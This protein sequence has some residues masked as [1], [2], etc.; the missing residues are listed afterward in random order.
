M[1]ATHILWRDDMEK[2]RCES[3]GLEIDTE[4]AVDIELEYDDGVQVVKTCQACAKS[5]ILG[6]RKMANHQRDP[7]EEHNWDRYGG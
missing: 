2:T 1:E 5:F 6:V 4:K 3:C 7:Y